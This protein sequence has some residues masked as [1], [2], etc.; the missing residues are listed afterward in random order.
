MPSE[1]ES[2]LL[3]LIQE[4]DKLGI[5]YAI[6]GSIASS[7][8]GIPRA[9]QD[10]DILAELQEEHIELI[11]R[12]LE[13]DFYISEGS[14]ISAVQ[15]RTSFNI[16]HLNSLHKLDVFVAEPLG[17]HQEELARSQR[18]PLAADSTQELAFSSPE[19]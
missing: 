10:A 18:F 15:A 5:R 9:T 1:L 14:V 13:K 6:G 2:V 12:A 16:I 17:W 3:R 7:L 4:F 8:H 11:V 19:D